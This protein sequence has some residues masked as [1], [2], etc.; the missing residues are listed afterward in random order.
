MTKSILTYLLTLTAVGALMGSLSAA[1]DVKGTYK[2]AATIKQIQSLKVGDKY[3][4]VCNM[5]KSIT[6]KEVTKQEQVVDL[7]HDGGAIH[8]PSCKKKAVV[9]YSGPVGKLM[10]SST[11][12]TY[13]NG[14]GKECMYLVP[15]K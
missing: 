7:C 11:R 8:C 14:E 3:A 2:T 9:K 5:C 4:M 6:V 13:V 15:L 1:P 12:L 10:P